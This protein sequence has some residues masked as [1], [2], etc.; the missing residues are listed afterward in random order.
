MKV[1]LIQCPSRLGALALV[2]GASLA[3]APQLVAD[4]YHPTSGTITPSPS[5]TPEVLKP[6]YSGPYLDIAALLKNTDKGEAMDEALG[7]KTLHGTPLTPRTP[8]CFPAESRDVMWEMDWV[9]DADG[10]LRPLNFD[11]NNDGKIDEK[12]RDGI[13]G[14][15]TW[16][17]WPGGNE[18]FWNWLA[19]DGYGLND[20]VAFL[21][22]RRR[23]DRFQ[24]TGAVNQPGYKANKDPSKKILGLYLDVVDEKAKDAKGNSKHFLTPPEW[25]TGKQAPYPGDQTHKDLVRLPATPGK[26][27]EQIIAEQS[28]LFRMGDVAMFRDTVEKLTQMGDGLD[29]SIYGF[30]SGVVGLRLFLNPDFFGDTKAASEA[31]KYWDERVIKTN[32]RYYTDR[33][34]FADTRLVRPFRVGMSCGFC[35]VAPHPLSP[36]ADRENP[37]WHNLSS[38]IGNQ[39]WKPATAFGN[40]QQPNS[41]IYHFLASQQ[42]GT[43]DTSAISTD[44]I[45]NANTINAVYDIVPRLARAGLNPTELQSR[46]N[47]LLPSIEDPGLPVKGDGTDWRHTPRVLLDGSDSIGAFGALARVYLNIG[48]FYEQWGRCHNAVIGF[49]KQRP[50]SV[51]TCQRNSVYWQTNVK[52][53]VPYLAAFFTLQ[54][55]GVPS[56]AAGTSAITPSPAPHSSTQ[57]MKLAAATDPHAGKPSKAAQAY[58]ALN[59]GEQRKRGR[60]VWLDNCAICHSS[61]QPA[62]FGLTFARKEKGEPWEAQAEPKDDIYTLPFDANDWG[63]FKNSPAYA[64][65]KKRL[66]AL[67]DPKGTSLAG[68]PLTDNHPFWK[69]NF[70]STDIRV[71]VTLVGTNSGRAMATN[72]IHESVWDNFS[73][74]TYKELASVG[75]VTYTNPFTGV[76]QTYQAPAGGRGYY[77][78]ASHI[79]LWATAPF[80][81][82]NTLGLFRE[83]PSVAGRLVQFSDSIRRMLWSSN[84]S[85]HRPVLSDDEWQWLKSL[86]NEEQPFDAIAPETLVSREGDLRGTGS[87]S[88]A[89][90]KGMIYRVNVPETFF[91]FAPSFA[92]PFVKGLFGPCL[93]WILST[94]L[95]LL[96]V[97]VLLWLAWKHRPLYVGITLIVLAVL[98][99]AGIAV[100]GIGGGGSTVGVILM[101]VSGL[102]EL[103]SW[104]WWII[105]IGLGL[106][107]LIFIQARMDDLRTPRVLLGLLLLGIAYALYRSIVVFAVVESGYQKLAIA[108]T[109]L[110]LAFLLWYRLRPTL[111]GFAHAFFLALALITAGLGY[112]ANRFIAGKKLFTVPLANVTVGP[113][114]LKVGPIPKGTPVNLMMNLD[115]ESPHFTKALVSLVIAMAEIK[116]A[117][118]T[119]D[120]AYEI[121]SDRAGQALLNA[122]KCPDFTLDRGH[123]FGEHLDPDPAKNDQAK[124]DLISFLKTL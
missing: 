50:F 107:G 44:H 118:V 29:Y 34:V 48:T 65:Y 35:H 5:P 46:A 114:P 116:K 42:A 72:A 60:E 8:E 40:L 110:V 79:S 18:G 53:R 63:D 39:Y 56:P 90:D 71:P 58:L 64:K 24:R 81:H 49:T 30:P 80:L 117:G 47:V 27:V 37:E 70:L 68:D 92:E 20:Y 41:F 31:R 97:P 54:H 7:G 101:A 23:N 52:Y 55:P 67:V 89:N 83:D 78:P 17:W 74:T 69:E 119:G 43:V 103:A 91:E 57:P 98:V 111:G 11:T 99:A 94:G 66:R 10:Q 3:S 32:D 14:R 26:R 15:N 112:T 88:A 62:G 6:E 85:N 106:L 51:D 9:P 16:V 105:A 115:H 21:D 113:L 33:D 59:D 4:S 45:N 102:L 73:S 93:T 36:P 76:E 86:P 84:R 28:S 124:E 22:S 2:A 100:S 61:K 120:A 122:S 1:F 82:N 25:E 19:Q 38:N 96:L 13:R 123:L 12:E 77:R 104:E 75:L 95:W 87:P 109:L 121:L 108:A